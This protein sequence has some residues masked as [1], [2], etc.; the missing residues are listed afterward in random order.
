MG[1]R[2]S[3]CYTQSILCSREAVCHQSYVYSL[4]EAVVDTILR[5]SILP[6]LSLNGIEY[7]DIIEGSFTAATFAIFIE[8][9]LDQMNPYPGPNS[10]IVMDNCRIHKS[11]DILEMITERCHQSTCLYH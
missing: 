1:N 6:A 2:W 9:L 5:Y 4:T 11:P 8:G 10:V 7:V 3:A